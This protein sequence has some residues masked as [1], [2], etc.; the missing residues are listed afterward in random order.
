[1]RGK[2]RKA[3][4]QEL[5]AIRSLQRN[6]P[7]PPPTTR[8]PG[9]FLSTK[10]WMRAYCAHGGLNFEETWARMIA[11]DRIQLPPGVGPEGYE[12]ES[13]LMRFGLPN[14]A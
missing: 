4:K 10:R 12:S 13:L 14:P 3:N 5:Q 2:Q 11:E 1:M 7:Q 9:W 8:G 6:T